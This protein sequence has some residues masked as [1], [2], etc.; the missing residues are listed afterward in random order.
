MFFFNPMM[1]QKKRVLYHQMRIHSQI[2]YISTHS[3]TSFQCLLTYPF[4]SRSLPKIGKRC[5][6]DF[7][8]DKPLTYIDNTRILLNLVLPLNR[9]VPTD[10]KTLRIRVQIV[11]CIFPCII[12]GML[13]PTKISYPRLH[14]N[15]EVCMKMPVLFDTLKM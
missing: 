7:P 12:V 15:V 14:L 8:R 6:Q 11:H 1:I 2:N 9:T 3:P 10:N 4:A 5:G 13:F